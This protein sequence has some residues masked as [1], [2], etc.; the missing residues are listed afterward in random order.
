MMRKKVIS[1]TLVAA[2]L[3]GSFLM[4]RQSVQGQEAA[5]ASYPVLEFQPVPAHRGPAGGGTGY[6]AVYGETAQ[7]SPELD[8][9][10]QQYISGADAAAKSAARDKALES[11]GKVFDSQQKLREQELQRLETELTQLREKLKKRTAM[12]QQLI[13]HRFEGMVQ[14]AEGLGWGSGPHSAR[15]RSLAAPVGLPQTL[16]VPK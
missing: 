12:R 4:V 2:A 7:N 6:V 11:L 10:I 1:S 14:D 3:C 9:A 16:P 15:V 8:A 5:K 13:E